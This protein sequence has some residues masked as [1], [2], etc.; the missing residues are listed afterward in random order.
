MKIED[1]HSVREQQIN[2][3]DAKLALAALMLLV[4]LML[5]GWL[6]TWFVTRPMCEA[7]IARQ[8]QD[9]ERS[10]ELLAE[11]SEMLKELQK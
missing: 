10:D 8:E 2:R 7:V 4:A 11:A 5:A 1:Y 9:L 3:R 6:H